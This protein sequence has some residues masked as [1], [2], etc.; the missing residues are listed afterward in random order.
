MCALASLFEIE[1][2]ILRVHAFDLQSV[3][4]MSTGI[5]KKPKQLRRFTIVS[6]SYPQ[7]GDGTTQANEKLDRNLVLEMV[8]QKKNNRIPTHEIA[9]SE[10]NS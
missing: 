6:N 7:P 8:K 2:V 1:T 3:L 5:T 4:C 9:F 10:F